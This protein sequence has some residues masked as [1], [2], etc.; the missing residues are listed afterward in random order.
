LS[1]NT[2]HNFS[3]V[4]RTSVFQRQQVRSVIA[5]HWSTWAQC[6]SRQIYGI[7]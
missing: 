5:N 4:L 6:V 1:V 2:V 3:F 7:L